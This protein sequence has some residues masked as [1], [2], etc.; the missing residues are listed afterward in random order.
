MSSDDASDSAPGTTGFPPRDS[1][2]E[3]NLVAELLE[4]ISTLQLLQ[5]YWS[6]L[7]EELVDREEAT[8]DSDLDFILLNSH[9]NLLRA[10][11]V[12]SRALP[13]EHNLQLVS[14]WVVVDELSHF[15]V[16]WIVFDRNVYRD[17]GLQ[18]NDVVLECVAFELEVPDA[19]E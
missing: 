17:A 1:L 14:I 2:L 19:L 4:R 9:S 5:L 6:V 18:L 13:H 11:L 12:H 8:A 10:E 15:H 3:S 7:V 16:H